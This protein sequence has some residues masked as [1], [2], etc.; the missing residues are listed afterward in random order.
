MPLKFKDVAHFYLGGKIK[1]PKGE[2]TLDMI[3][4]ER[5]EV[6]CFD[7]V[8]AYWPFEQIK[9]ILKPLPPDEEVVEVMSDVLPSFD[10]SIEESE[11]ENMNP[12][13]GSALV[14]FAL[15]KAGYDVFDLINSGEA[16]DELIG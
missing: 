12:T 13:H 15:C 11:L 4:I 5:K 2:G 16:I 10:I 6:V 1:T 9:P 14:T 3:D 7:L 8:E